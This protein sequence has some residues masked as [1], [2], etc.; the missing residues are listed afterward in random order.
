MLYADGLTLASHLKFKLQTK[1]TE[2]KRSVMMKIMI[3]DEKIK[4]VREDGRLSCAG[5]RKN[6]GSKSILWRC[7][8]CKACSGISGRMKQDD[9]FRCRP[10]ASQRT[11]RGEES[12]DKELGGQSFEIMEK[13]CSLC[14]IIGA[15][16]GELTVL[17]V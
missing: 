13:R 3:D 6:L 16:G 10:C 15:R 2:V 4:K 7:W 5:G 17:R 1:R 11:D 14:E 8:V 9:E 12:P